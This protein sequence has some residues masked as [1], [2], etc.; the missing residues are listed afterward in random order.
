MPTLELMIDAT[1][2][3]RGQQQAET[4]LK[5]VQ[6]AA[7]RTQASVTGVGT[8]FQRSFQVTQGGV[9]IAT[10][11]AQTAAAFQSMNTAMAGFA[12]ARTLLEIGQT[13]SQL[14]ALRGGATA[15][16]GALALLGRSI[17]YVGLALSAGTALYAIFGGRV[18]D[19]TKKIN[20][21]ADALGRLQDKLRETAIRTGYGQPDARTG[22]GGT[23]DA[24]TALRLGDAQQT[25]TAG[26]AAALFGVSEQQ[27]RYALARSGLGEAALEYTPGRSQ[28]F[29]PFTGQARG[30]APQQRYRMQE[31]YRG[32]V[33]AAGEDILNQRR[34]YAGVDEGRPFSVVPTQPFGVQDPYGFGVGRNYVEISRGQQSQVDR[35]NAQAS[36]ERIAESMERAARSAEAIGGAFGAAAFDV[37]AGVQSLRQALASFVAQFARQGLA[38]AGS[39]FA[40]SLFNATSRQVAGGSPS[41]SPGRMAGDPP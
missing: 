23:I 26:D 30:Y 18:A 38:D 27:L 36:A 3:Q 5:G 39:S 29:D 33:I 19:T 12:G 6:N 10:G 13:A 7:E 2:M 31:F 35:E 24:L 4:A 16:S 22:V 25:F 17:P 11:I 8:S 32:Q 28:E 20:E 14:A 9:Q 15:A 40:S 37:L 21:Q 41:Y 34:R 1:G